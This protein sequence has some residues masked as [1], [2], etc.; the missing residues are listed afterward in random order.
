MFQR[1]NEK[2]HATEYCRLQRISR[3]LKTPA[4]SLAARLARNFAARRQASRQFE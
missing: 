2:R 1:E 3:R 4:T